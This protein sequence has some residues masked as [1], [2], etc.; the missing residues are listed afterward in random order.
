MVFFPMDSKWFPW[1]WA[2]GKAGRKVTGGYLGA[3]ASLG[4]MQQKNDKGDGG[5][6]E[7]KGKEK[8]SMKTAK[9]SY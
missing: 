6:G 4:K 1:S 9:G 8:V 3:C 2:V 7:M 5:G